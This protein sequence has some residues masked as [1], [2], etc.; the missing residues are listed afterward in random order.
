MWGLMRG[1]L[2]V[3]VLTLGCLLILP[4][5]AVIRHMFL[6]SIT[7]TLAGGVRALVFIG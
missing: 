6:F 1:S 4:L 3:T 2:L 7:E 5:R